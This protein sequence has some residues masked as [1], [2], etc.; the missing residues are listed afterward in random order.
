VAALFE[1]NARERRRLLTSSAEGALLAFS[2]EPPNLSPA[3][4]DATL[5]AM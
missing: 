4:W 2:N 1:G 3:A 5:D